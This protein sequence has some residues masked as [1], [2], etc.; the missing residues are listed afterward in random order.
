M[1][2][3]P[4][5]E[6]VSDVLRSI[7]R[8]NPGNLFL[9]C[10]YIKQTCLDQSYD[11]EAYLAVL[12]LFQFNPNMFDLETTRVILLKAMTS[13]PNNDFSLCLYLLAEEHHQNTEIVTLI[14]LCNSLES[15]L[16]ED[17][18]EFLEQ[19]PEVLDGKVRSYTEAEENYDVKIVGFEHRI[20]EF[21]AHVISC[22]YQVVDAKVVSK[23]LGGLNDALLAKFCEA[24]GWKMAEGGKIFVAH[25]EEIVKSKNIVESIRFDSLVPIMVAQNKPC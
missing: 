11:I 24:H 19:H 23:M 2:R 10:K 4:T 12:K 7:E 6:E 14:E 3:A 5:K 8:Y 9:F 13:L 17:V 25:Q 16:F 18:W 21:I 15:C 20:R 1:D 22:T